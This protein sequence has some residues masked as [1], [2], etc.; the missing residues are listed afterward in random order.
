MFQVFKQP[1]GKK[2]KRNKQTSNTDIDEFM[3]A[4]TKTLSTPNKPDEFDSTCMSFAAKLRKMDGTQQIFAESLMH[5]V[6][7]LGLLNKLNENYSVTDN[8]KLQ[9]QHAN[10]FQNNYQPSVETQLTPSGQSSY[11]VLNSWGN[12]YPRLVQPPQP[13]PDDSTLSSASS[14]FTSAADCYNNA[15]RILSDE[16]LE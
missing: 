8:N 3:K 9:S 7:T 14:T 2:V 6:C 1:P 11:T 12:Q 15:I 10:N 13:S 4:C 16:S 5:Q